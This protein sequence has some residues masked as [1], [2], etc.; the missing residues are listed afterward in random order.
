MTNRTRRPASS[1]S[2]P[3]LLAGI[4]NAPQTP[5]PEPVEGAGDP[6]TIFADRIPDPS[7][8]GL[9]WLA[10]SIDTLEEQATRRYQERYGRR[11]PL[12]HRK[13]R[14]PPPRP[15]SLR[16]AVMKSEVYLRSQLQEILEGQLAAIEHL[17][18]LA[19]SD[20]ASAYYAGYLAALRAVAASVSIDLTRLR[21]C[22]EFNRADWQRQIA[23]RGE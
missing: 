17:P 8:A 13:P 3:F 7:A 1:A 20:I 23:G 9:V 18:L 2:Q 4:H 5:Q 6:L 14:Q 19:S 11:P 16:G 21:T 15:R 22:G 12:H 10:F